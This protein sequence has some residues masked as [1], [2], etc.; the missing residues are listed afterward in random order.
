MFFKVCFYNKIFIFSD[1]HKRF[2]Q[3]NFPSPRKYLEYKRELVNK[4]LDKSMRSEIQPI[5]ADI[6]SHAFVT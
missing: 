5:S 2:Q 3:V 4:S 1:I 6:S